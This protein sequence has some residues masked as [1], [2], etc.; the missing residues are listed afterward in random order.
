MQLRTQVQALHQRDRETRPP[1]LAHQPPAV[2]TD[3]QDIREGMQQIRLFM[4]NLSRK[5]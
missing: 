2:E 4:Q 1:D 5:L 3:L